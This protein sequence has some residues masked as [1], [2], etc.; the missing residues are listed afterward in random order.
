L[1]K[2]IELYEHY[3]T[4][5]PHSCSGNNPSVADPDPIGSGPFWLDPDVWTGSGSGY[6]S[7]ASNI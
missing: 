1:R 2:K 5:L 4:L 3:D 6:G 7:E